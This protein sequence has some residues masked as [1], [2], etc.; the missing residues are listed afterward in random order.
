M[1]PFSSLIVAVNWEHKSYM[2]NETR[3][4]YTRCKMEYITIPKN[5]AFVKKDKLGFMFHPVS[6][7]LHTL[8]NIAT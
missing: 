1:L 2:E 4:V 8:N 5:L 6:F 3:K 7:Y